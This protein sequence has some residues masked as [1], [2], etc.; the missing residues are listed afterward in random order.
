[1]PRPKWTRQVPCRVATSRYR[2]QGDC[3]IIIFCR[4][5]THRSSKPGCPC[6]LAESAFAWGCCPACSIR[7]FRAPPGLLP[8]L[9]GFRVAGSSPLAPALTPA[10][11][12]LPLSGLGL[13]R[14]FATCVSQ[15]GLPPLRGIAVV[16]GWARDLNRR[17]LTLQGSWG[18]AGLAGPSHPSPLLLL[19][20]PSD[21]RTGQNPRIRADSENNSIRGVRFGGIGGIDNGF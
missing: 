19:Y 20:A 15:A 8:L 14:R 21:K 18:R 7:E 17:C 6:L 12:G 16:P 3:C 2:V 5:P 1:M 9:G 13:V 11:L 4:G 10:L